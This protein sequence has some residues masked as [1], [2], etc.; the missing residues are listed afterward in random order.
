MYKLFI[1]HLEFFDIFLSIHYHSQNIIYSLVEN[2]CF[3]K[4]FAI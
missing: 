3:H 1:E 2:G 4:A